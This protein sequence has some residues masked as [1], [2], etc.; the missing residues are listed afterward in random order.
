MIADWLHEPLIWIHDPVLQAAI[1]GT[2]LIG[3]L[4]FWISTVVKLRAL[5]K[6]FQ[7]FRLSTEATIGELSNG[8]EALRSAPAC[9]PVPSAMTVQGL[10]LTTRAKVLR[11]QRR[12]ETVSSIAAALG[13]QREEVEL[14][15]KL[16]RLLE[17]PAA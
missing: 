6:T 9:D 2:V 3:N 17:I 14:L 5:R 13:V 11:M 10:N 12:G 16:E 7:A 1:A 4:L 15:L 8:I